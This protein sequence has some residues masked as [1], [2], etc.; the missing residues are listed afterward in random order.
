MNL[1]R[2]WNYLQSSTSDQD[3]PKHKKLCLLTQV[4][5]IYA[6]E[7]R[8][9]YLGLESLL[10]YSFKNDESETRSSPLLLEELQHERSNYFRNNCPTAKMTESNP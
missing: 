9:L 3:T 6:I 2:N 4:K 7:H 8:N 10:E 1:Q 5:I